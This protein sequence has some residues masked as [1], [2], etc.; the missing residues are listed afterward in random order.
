[1]Y[2]AVVKSRQPFKEKKVA[3]GYALIKLSG[4]FVKILVT[5]HDTVYYIN[6]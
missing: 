4:V 6:I 2:A 5:M 3:A 1:M